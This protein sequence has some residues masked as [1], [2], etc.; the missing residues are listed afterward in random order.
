MRPML[1]AAASASRAE[2]SSWL[3][4]GR[5]PTCR[6]A[7][8][9][10]FARVSGHGTLRSSARFAILSMDT[11]SRGQTAR[12]LAGSPVQALARRHILWM[13][14]AADERR[15]DGLVILVMATPPVGG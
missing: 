12:T 15:G 6:S 13:T 11:P 10:T 7:W 8:R 14:L 2:S 3:R 9:A 5:T 1:G 4:R